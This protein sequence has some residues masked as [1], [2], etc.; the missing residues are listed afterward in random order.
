MLNAQLRSCKKT[1]DGVSVFLKDRSHRCC[2]KNFTKRSLQGFGRNQ[3]NFNHCLQ[4][5][6][7][8]EEA[9]A[10]LCRLSS[11]F[12]LSRYSHQARQLG[13]IQ[14]LNQADHPT[15]HTFGPVPCAPFFCRGG[16]IELMLRVNFPH[17]SFSPSFSF[18][19]FFQVPIY[20]N[21]FPL[22]FFLLH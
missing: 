12:K 4:T 16:F 1:G 11:A 3:T 22:F 9:A 19:F 8:L 7:S 18:F 17:V 15:P 20:L 5:P 14:T 6:P 21:S 13:F 2:T 10:Y